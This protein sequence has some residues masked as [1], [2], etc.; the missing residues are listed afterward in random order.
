MKDRI[1]ELRHLWG[2]GL[3]NDE[4][5][6]VDAARRRVLTTH[7]LCQAHVEFLEAGVALRTGLAMVDFCGCTTTNT[8]L[9]EGT[10]LS[11]QSVNKHVKDEAKAG[12]KYEFSYSPADAGPPVA[13]N[14]GRGTEVSIPATAEAQN[15]FAGTVAASEQVTETVEVMTPVEQNLQDQFDRLD[16]SDDD[17]D[18][19]PDL[20]PMPDELKADWRMLPK[21]AITA[22]DSLKKHDMVACNWDSGWEV[23][24]V[25][26]V[27][28]TPITDSSLFYVKFPTNSNC[29]PCHL[30]NGQYGDG[31]ED[32][33]AKVVRPICEVRI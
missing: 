9:R 31:P 14:N 26:E 23:G 12:R 15:E 16:A 28:S 11:I 24:Y 8:G 22:R 6:K 30:L 18:E 20:G 27:P 19:N 10:R 33:W 5:G 13:G 29:W 25:H 21:A 7:W 4:L 32:L 2:H 1:G 17:E 3:T